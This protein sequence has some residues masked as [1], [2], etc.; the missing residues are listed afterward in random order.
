MRIVNK[1]LTTL[2][3]TLTTLLLLVVI[4]LMLVQNGR[5]NNSIA[6]I[7]ADQGNKN[8]NAEVSIGGIQG[9]PLNLFSLNEIRIS[10]NDST[11]LYLERIHVNYNLMALLQKEVRIRNLEVSDLILEGTQYPDSSWNF[12]KLL[13]EP[14]PKQKEKEETSRP[15]EWRI[16]VNRLLLDDLSAQLN[17]LANNKI[18]S[19]IQVDGALDFSF[20]QDS[21]DLKMEKLSVETQS[22]ELFV[23]HM[24]GKFRNIKQQLSWEDL[25]IDLKETKLRSN[26]SIRLD[27]LYEHQAHILFDP[28]KLEALNPW[29]EAMKLYGSPGINLDIMGNGEEQKLEFNLQEGKQKVHLTGNM[30]HLKSK[31]QYQLTLQVEGLNGEHWTRKPKL[32]SKVEG[33]LN[34]RGEGFDLRESSTVIQGNFKDV[35]FEAYTLNHLALRIDKK[36]ETLKG[37]IKANTRFGNISSRFDL[38]QILQEPEYSVHTELA[39]VDLSKFPGNKELHSDLNLRLRSSGKG[40]N[41]DSLKA[42][43]QMDVFDSYF[44]GWSVSSMDLLLSYDRGY[45]D[46]GNLNLN[47][48][49]AEVQ[50]HGEGNLQKQ[51]F[52]KFDI[53]PK[54][55]GPLASAFDFPEIETKGNIAGQIEGKRD[56]LNLSARYN[57]LNVNY[58][59]L[60]VARL[61]GDISLLSEDSLLTGETRVTADSSY[62]GGQQVKQIALQSSYGKS[63]L[64]NSLDLIVNDSLS[65]FTQTDINIKQDPVFTIHDLR[66]NIGDHKWNSTT[67]S[68]N[69]TLAENAIR[70]DTFQLQSGEQKIGLNGTLDF[71]GEENLDFWIKDLNLSGLPLLSGFP[72][73]LYGTVNSGMQLTGEAS[74]PELKGFVNIND[75][76]LDTIRLNRITTNFHYASNKLDVESN[77]DSKYS[78]SFQGN[79]KIPLSFSLTDSF[80]MPDKNTP[81]QASLKMESFDVQNAN[82]FLK[83]NNMQVSGSVNATVDVSN[84]IGNPRFDGSFQLTE[85]AFFYPAQGMAY[86]NIEVNS[87]FD[88]QRFLLDNAYLSSGGGKLEINGFADLGFARDESKQEIS[89]RIG[90]ENFRALKSNK[91][92]AYIEPSVNI[93]GTVTK[94][95]VKGNVKITRST[96]NADAFRRQLSVKSDNPNPPLLVKA[97]IDTTN[98]GANQFNNVQKKASQENIYKNLSL[99]LDLTIPGNT[100]VQGKDMNFE[101][102]GKLKAITK[103]GQIDLFGT[104]NIGRGFFEFYGKRF[105]FKKGN[106]TFTGGRE[107]NPRLDFILGY[108]FRDQERELHTMTLRIEG[109]SKQPK[110]SF[111]LDGEHIEEKYAFSYLLFGKAPGN[112]TSGEQMSLE[113]NAADIARSLAIGKVSDIVTGTLRSSF[114]LDVVEIG[115]GK[116]WKSG[117]VKIGKYIT[118]DL[119]LNYQQT[120]AFDKREKMIEPEKITLEYQL[121][122]SLF[123]QATNQMPNSGFDLI[124]KRTWK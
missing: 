120:F 78:R 123:L 82:P 59:S 42:E 28:L 102:Q 16:T 21:I 34:A 18:P 93:T 35:I 33:E 57:L 20:K 53:S 80:S 55:M 64:K 44:L 15:S 40:T 74:A 104:L 11:I 70:T 117:N 37:N 111:T 90:G 79:I 119:Y 72:D 89:F 122:R 7:L 91:I 75:P 96:I 52:L 62:L 30:K 41:F 103:Q 61:H 19:E 87:H 1:I 105:D 29:L 38:K 99:T 8:L 65:L 5:L 14:E 94:P 54:N 108:D 85:G 10:Q 24:E 97:M 63:G 67:D 48:D 32:R 100:W 68:S 58:D 26:G 101:L 66:L 6:S 76:G 2:I 43:I 115:G 17:P 23:E 109:Q 56:S 92:E 110:L 88:N 3:L 22:P 49:Y 27:D 51:N 98:M 77:L 95:D 83:K 106:L 46:L 47:S 60:M 84:N 45:Y 4:L 36:K 112:L 31:P 39:H 69:I 113:E 116:T 118:D 73:K 25:S 71:K 107:I 114:G 124:F 12:I 81:I 86:Q 121:M 13:P 50:A 9:N